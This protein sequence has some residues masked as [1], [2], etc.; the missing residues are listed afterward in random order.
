M[1]KSSNNQQHLRHTDFSIDTI[2][3]HFFWW[4]THCN[5]KWMWFNG[6]NSYSI[7]INNERQQQ[8]QPKMLRKIV[9]T[10]FLAMIS[11]WLAVS[12][13]LMAFI[14]MFGQFFVPLN[15]WW[16]LS[17]FFAFFFQNF[18]IQWIRVFCSVY[19]NEFSCSRK[20]GHTKR[21]TKKKFVDRGKR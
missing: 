14:S 19:T 18:S 17:G 13:H 1:Q 8:Q 4:C 15:S 3:I 21:H 5:L 2:R 10:W 12:S 16:T 20:N 9:F 7:H 6:N 11:V